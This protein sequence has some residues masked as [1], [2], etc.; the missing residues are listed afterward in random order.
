[1]E[2]ADVERSRRVVVLWCTSGTH[3]KY[4]VRGTLSTLTYLLPTVPRPEYT[5]GE[6]KPDGRFYDA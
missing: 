5:R 1:M 4:L 3:G 6:S 2:I